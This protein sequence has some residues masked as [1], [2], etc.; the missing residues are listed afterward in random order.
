MSFYFKLCKKSMVRWAGWKKLN[1]LILPAC[2][3]ITSKLG[4]L[5]HLKSIK[6]S[7]GSCSRGHGPPFI[8]METGLNCS[9]RQDFFPPHRMTWKGSLLLESKPLALHGIML[10]EALWQEFQSPSLSKEAFSELYFSVGVFND[11]SWPF[12]IKKNLIF[13]LY[14]P[15]PISREQLY[16]LTLLSLSC[17][18]PCHVL[19]ARSNFHG[20]RLDH[21]LIS[22]GKQLAAFRARL[23]Q[24][25]NTAI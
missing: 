2:S 1:I 4:F 8:Y 9:E 22:N 5:W 11:M 15:T 17:Q 12:P 3:H 13:C 20:D 19:P 6:P 25:K 18:L 10:L 21:E 24:L 14:P 7:K 16:N 23:Y